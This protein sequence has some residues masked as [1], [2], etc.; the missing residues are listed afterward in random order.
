MT[1]APVIG[2]ARCRR[3]SELF[4]AGVLL[5]G[6]GYLA[7]LPPFEGFDEPAHY[8]SARQI[9]YTD[10]VPIRGH[11]F[12]DRF[13]QDYEKA[14]PM[15]WGSRNPPFDQTGSMTYHSFFANAD[16]LAHYQVY[17]DK[18][19]TN[20]FVPG[21][22]ANW[23]SQHPPLYYMLMAPIVRLTERL[24]F[25]TQIFVLRIVSY[26]LAFAGLMAGWVAIRR[27][28]GKVIPGDVAAS[29]MLF[30]IIVPMFF[31]EFARMG[32]DSLC[33]FF[34]G[35][36]CIFSYRLFYGEE[37]DARSAAG[38]GVCLGLGLLTKAL[39]L[40]VFAS[41]SAFMALRAW[42]AG[43]DSVQCRRRI[44]ALALVF[45]LALAIGGGWYLYNLIEYGSIVGG[46]EFVKLAHEGGLLE[47]FRQNFSLFYFLYDL[48]GMAASWSWAGSWSLVHV[49]PFLQII[50]LLLA[51]WLIVNYVLEAWRFRFDD[52][53]WL[54]AW[55]AGAFVGGLTYHI[56]VAR[57]VGIPAGSGW[58]LNILA[59]LL[60][61][62][63][64]Y[65]VA[66][67]DRSSRERLVLCVFLFFAVFFLA[68]VLWAQMALFSGCAV[69]DDHKYYQFAGHFF[70]LDRF[71]TVVAHLSVLAWPTVGL[72]SFGVGFLC[73]IAGLVSFVMTRRSQPAS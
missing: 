37:S 54:P 15:P 11:S 39:F 57:A 21:S 51:A 3:I 64:G 33:L 20:A 38:V 35:L 41:C 19:A 23:E 65:G 67:A 49:S 72:V 70:C 18:P 4:A 59:P 6:I 29:Y 14:G 52:P 40:P 68:A 44:T 16:A 71:G 10:T 36:T 12:I 45:F 13:V 8:S 26:L 30:P 69:K 22:T 48:V 7:I 56:F 25:L 9:A 50:L 63:T 42:R 60:A 17:Q 62:A 27:Y 31:P 55:V 43:G 28:A 73:L 66:R 46:N 32:N 34:L 47:N 5:I 53:V 24:P 1:A 61:I 58:Y 2:E